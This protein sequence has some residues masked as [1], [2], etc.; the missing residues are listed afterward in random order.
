MKKISRIRNEVL[1]AQYFATIAGTIRGLVLGI[2]LMIIFI[3]CMGHF[4]NEQKVIVGVVFFVL[5]L[6]SSYFLSKGKRFFISLIFW[7]FLDLAIFSCL[8]SY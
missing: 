1:E 7:G 3:V 4:T 5:T 2:K 8:L 6:I